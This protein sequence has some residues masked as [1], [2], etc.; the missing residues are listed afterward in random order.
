MNRFL[1]LPISDMCLQQLFLTLPAKLSTEIHTHKYHCQ[2]THQQGLHL[3]RK[4][5]NK[6]SIFSSS[7]YKCFL[8]NIKGIFRPLLS[9]E[10]GGERG[11]KRSPGAGAGAG[12][13][14][15]RP[16]SGP[17]GGACRPPAARR[18][19][20]RPGTARAGRL[21]AGDRG[22]WA[23]GRARSGFSLSGRALTRLRD[24]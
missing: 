17:A 19:E 24:A 20:Q 8:S 15:V 23:R 10:L 9:A 3:Q 18:A 16:P 7:T 2:F 6:T 12:S 1:I 22:D 21:C 4:P 5:P 13:S 14:P 11:M